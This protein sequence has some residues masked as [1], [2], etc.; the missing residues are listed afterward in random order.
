MH[1]II[2]ED[3]GYSYNG[4]K[5]RSKEEIYFSWYLDGI[6]KYT[7]SIEYEPYSIEVIKKKRVKFFRE[8]TKP[9]DCHL[10]REFSYTPDF[11]IKWNSTP[12]FSGDSLSYLWHICSDRRFNPKHDIYCN[13]VDKGHIEYISYIDVKGK[14]TKRNPA[15]FPIKQKIIYQ[16]KGLYVQK[17]VPKEFFKAIDSYPERYL[18]ADGGKQKRKIS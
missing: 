12:A 18:W 13:I 14:A 2:K 9:N 15:S 10:L 1:K 5:Y 3:K 6:K 4:V 7:D 11:V 16:M 8:E 17:I